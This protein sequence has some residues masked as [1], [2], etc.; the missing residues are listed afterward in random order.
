MTIKVDLIEPDGMVI[1]FPARSWELAH[2]VIEALRES[3]PKG[4]RMEESRVQPRGSR[5]SGRRC[6]VRLTFYHID[7]RVKRL[8]TSGAKAFFEPYARDA[9]GVES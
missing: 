4:Y 9:Q 1:R 2:D 3:P 7:D 8:A 5:K 6:N